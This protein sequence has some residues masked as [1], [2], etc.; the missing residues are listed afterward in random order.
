MELREIQRPL[1][2][3]YCVGLQTLRDRPPFHIN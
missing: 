1:K 3:R 2:Q